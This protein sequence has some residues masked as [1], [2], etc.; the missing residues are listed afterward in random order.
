MVNA[1]VSASPTTPCCAMSSLVRYP[2]MLLLGLAQSRSASL[3]TVTMSCPSCTFFPDGRL[4]GQQSGRA[5]LYRR[6]SRYGSGQ[7]ASRLTTEGCRVTT[8]L[9]LPDAHQSITSRYDVAQQSLPFYHTLLPDDRKT[10]QA[11]LRFTVLA[12]CLFAWTAGAGT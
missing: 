10:G 2:A 11:L 5:P 4:S 1:S 6:S 9:C 8:Q 12:P 3:F 7:G